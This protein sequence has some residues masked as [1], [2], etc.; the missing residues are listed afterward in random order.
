MR[1]DCLRRSQRKRFNQSVALNDLQSILRCFNPHGER[2]WMSKF[3]RRTEMAVETDRQASRVRLYSTLMGRVPTGCSGVCVNKLALQL[4][5]QIWHRPVRCPPKKWNKIIN[6]IRWRHDC[7]F[8]GRLKSPWWDLRQL[9][10]GIL[11]YHIQVT[12][13]YLPTRIDLHCPSEI[14]LIKLVVSEM[15]FPVSPE[16]DLFL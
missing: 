8:V 4:N 11:Y 15:M 16:S 7:Y 14:P 6:V 5:M 9:K 12:W 10:Q 1:S 2:K 13:L 3:S